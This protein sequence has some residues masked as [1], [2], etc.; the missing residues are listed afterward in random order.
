MSLKT[1]HPRFLVLLAFILAVGVLR[2]VTAG[3]ITAI[4]NFSP[5]GAMALFG[6]AYFADKW[7]SYVFPLLTLFISDVLIMQIFF[8]DISTGLLYDGWIWNYLAVAAMVLCGQLII[9]KVSVANLIIAGIVSAVAHW[10]ISDL[11][12]WMSSLSIYSHDFNGLVECYIAAIPFMKNMIIG[13]LVYGAIMFFGFEF[14]KAK[15]PVL[16]QQ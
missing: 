14:T 2:T 9:R 12:M 7:K 8:R 6:G 13:N 16:A 3:S 10:L 15:Y 11:G 4:S 1:L 5:V